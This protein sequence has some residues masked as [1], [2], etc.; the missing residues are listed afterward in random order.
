MTTNTLLIAA[1]GAGKTTFLAK[2]ALRQTGDV[3]ITTYTEVNEEEIRRKI[4]KLNKTIPGNITVQTWFSFLIQHGIKP[5]QGC[6]TQ[7]KINGMCF[8]NTQS[9]VGTISNGRPIFY[10]EDGQFERYYFS[11]ERKI[12]SDK[13]SKFAFRCNEKSAGNVIDRISR[14]YPHIY[15]DEV[16]DLA[17]YDLEIL[18]LLF[19]SDSPAVLV[20]DPRQVTYLT[21]HDERFSQYKD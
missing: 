14:I 6:L 18:K 10:S 19:Q 13:L 5:Y 16:Q 17:G 3:L 21:H 4:I 7:E 20:G 11:K 12:Y 2:E 1:A 8:V 15:V 9:G